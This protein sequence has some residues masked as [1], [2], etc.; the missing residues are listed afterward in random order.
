LAWLLLRQPV[1]SRAHRAS[2]LQAPF[3]SAAGGAWPRRP[4]PGWG[5]IAL[6]RTT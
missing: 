5:D 3:R 6:I 1:R 2:H 4:G